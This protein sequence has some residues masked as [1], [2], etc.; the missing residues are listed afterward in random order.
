[1]KNTKCRMLERWWATGPVAVTRPSVMFRWSC[2]FHFVCP[3]HN[4]KIRLFITSSFNPG[5]T[6]HK[7][8]VIL[9]E[10]PTYYIIQ[11]R[12]HKVTGS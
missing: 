1:M 11:Q 4:S 10:H 8:R 9:T 2:L 5:L 12:R 3:N 6:F 7:M